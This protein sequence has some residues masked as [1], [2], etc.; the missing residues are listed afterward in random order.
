[1][2]DT[3]AATENANGDSLAD[4]WRTF[5]LSPY[6]R[7]SAVI[8]HLHWVALITAGP[9]LLL[10][11]ES[12]VISVVRFGEIRW[13]LALRDLGDPIFSYLTL[14]LFL[15]GMVFARGWYARIQP[16]FQSLLD[17]NILN[18]RHGGNI[19]DSFATFLNQ[20]KERLHSRKRYLVATFL[21]IVF[22]LGSYLVLAGRSVTFAGVL[23]NS[24]DPVRNWLNVLH[25]ATR[26]IIAAFIWGYFCGLALWALWITNHAIRQLTP[27]FRLRIQPIHSDKAGGLR[28]LG[29]LSGSV[30]LIIVVVC[31]PVAVF[32]IRGVT[33]VVQSRHCLHEIE[34]SA[35]QSVLMEKKDLVNC[36]VAINRAM[37]SASYTHDEA[38]DTIQ[39]LLD[40]G[41]APLEIVREFAEEIAEE[42]E[43]GV[44][45]SDDIMA[46]NRLSIALLL[47]FVF[48]L[49][50]AV[51]LVAWPLWDIHGSMVRQ[52]QRDETMLNAQ[53]V[54]LYE[55][56]DRHIE[57]RQW[58]EAQ[59][60]KSYLK[61][62]Q[63][64]LPDAINYP[65]WPVSYPRLLRRVVTP[66][67]LSAA[68]SYGLTLVN[69]AFSEEG[70]KL[71][72][73]LLKAIGAG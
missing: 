69:A 48:V 37:D 9:L 51:L 72:D 44:P 40:G 17:N 55:A 22:L 16:A 28:Q 59:S 3:I 33:T 39:A 66:S 26:W 29:D 71:F 18:D 64:M 56:L 8:S 34:S 10:I 24:S 54:S 38:N 45:L 31:I 43:D 65:T 61:I 20:Y 49:V 23:K 53:A 32:G 21:I 46:Q 19:H 36:L 13:T 68:L 4:F 1:M 2:N 62:V 11:L 50:L 5:Q 60:T 42:A 6:R 57:N 70:K 35:Q 73:E 30:G 7:E 52:R 41:Y 67:I 63:E 58:E 14:V 27:R 25:F 47:G 12:T 15:G